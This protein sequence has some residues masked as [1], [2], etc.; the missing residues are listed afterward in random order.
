MFGWG[1]A[2][3]L[4]VAG[5]GKD[6]RVAWWKRER[7]ALRLSYSRGVLAEDRLL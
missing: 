6:S 5:F 3:W 1:E 2:L 7:V 4:E